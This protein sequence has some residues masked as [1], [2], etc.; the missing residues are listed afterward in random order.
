MQLA[1]HLQPLSPKAFC[2][3]PGVWAANSMQK[4]GKMNTSIA[5]VIAYSLAEASASSFTP[6]VCLH[7]ITLLP[8]Y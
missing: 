4:V 8:V 1:A 7:P 6:S 2:G 3:V 5:A